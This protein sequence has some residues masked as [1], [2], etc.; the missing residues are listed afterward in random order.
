MT[1]VAAPEEDSLSSGA[2]CTAIL[3]ETK[4]NRGFL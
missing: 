3:P 1:G 4:K 2:F